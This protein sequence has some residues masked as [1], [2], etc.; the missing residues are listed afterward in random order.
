MD[1]LVRFCLPFCEEPDPVGFFLG[2]G[3]L[4]LPLT[5]H[6]FACCCLSVC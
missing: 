1:F 2:A 6:P 3:V 5:A 4:R